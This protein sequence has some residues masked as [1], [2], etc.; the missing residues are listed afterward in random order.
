MNMF[1]CYDYNYFFIERNAVPVYGVRMTAVKS[2]TVRKTC[3]RGK[4]KTNN[5]EAVTPVGKW[6]SC[7]FNKGPTQKVK[8]INL[9]AHKAKMYPRQRN[10][11]KVAARQDPWP[12]D[13]TRK[14]GKYTGKKKYWTKKIR[15]L[16]ASH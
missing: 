10:I 5:G 12:L 8:V 11:Y 9:R 4:M 14:K 2:P 13:R 16:P 15:G 6:L 7:T 1:Y 3:I